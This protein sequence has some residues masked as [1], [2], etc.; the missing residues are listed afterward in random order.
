MDESYKSKTIVM[1]DEVSV[2]NESK[3]FIHFS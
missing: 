3:M 1:Q 2:H